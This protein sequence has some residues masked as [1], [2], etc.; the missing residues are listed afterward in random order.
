MLNT[1]K[2]YIYNIEDPQ[3]NFDL[4]LEYDALGQSY[5]AISYYLRTANLTQDQILAYT[6]ILKIGTWFVKHECRNF[7]AE[8]MLQQA[9][10]LQPKRPEAYF[11]LSQLYEKNKKYLESYQ[12]STV[13]LEVC[14]FDSEPLSIDVGY[15]GKWG[16]IFERAITAW[17]CGKED[18]TRELLRLL[19]DKYWNELSE[20]YKNTVEFNITSLGCGHIFSHRY[21]KELYPGLNY[22][23]PGSENINENFSQVYQDM[24][25]LFMLDGKRNGTFLEVGGSLPY[26]GNN[27]AL[28]ERDFNWRGVSIEWKQDQADEYKKAR[29]NIDMI[30][31]DA[32]KL[33]YFDVCKKFAS[34]D[35]DFLQLDIEPARNTLEVLKMIPFDQFRFAVITYEHDYYVDVS[36][37]CRD[38]SRKILRD[39]GYELVIADVC[40]RDNCPFEDWWVHPALVSRERIDQ[41]KNLSSDLKSTDKKF[42]TKISKKKSILAKLNQS[43][44]FSAIN[45]N[46]KNDLWV[47]DNFYK[48]PDA[49]REFALQQE[50]VNSQTTQQFLFPGL[51]EE[52]ERIMGRTIT[53]WEEHDINGRFHY[54]VEG[55]AK[56][57]RCDVQTWIGIVYLTPNAPYQA[58]T[59]TFAGRDTNIVDRTHADIMQYFK[60]GFYNLDGIVFDPI[61][62][63]GNIYNRLV[64]IDS[65]Y[66]N[67]NLGFFGSTKENSRLWQMFF[68]D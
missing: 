1:L 39:L 51:K 61:D 43:S 5:T 6:C 8:T 36:R 57:Y 18:L 52:F 3:S 14:D 2:N 25:V 55:N 35:I 12:L 48:N 21:T 47:V 53:K 22:K 46:Y 41:I 26:H 32:L 54:G 58:G 44:S 68:F 9:V 66:L 10:A 38:Q 49:V 56:S 45:K 17:H 34:T 7:S 33:N 67:S 59:G 40:P 31:T 27:T 29:P 50:F 16:L 28:L 63:I 23:F 64:I 4:A 15:V 19:V 60:Q 11:L 37:S 42:I 65:K 20:S 24:F 62:T 30:C 13:G